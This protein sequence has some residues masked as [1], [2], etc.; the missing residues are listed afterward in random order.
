MIINIKSRQFPKQRDKNNK[1]T[2][3]IPAELEVLFTGFDLSVL[4]WEVQKRIAQRSSK[5][6]QIPSTFDLSIFD[7]IWEYWDNYYILFDPIQFN[8]S[9]RHSSFKC[10]DFPLLGNTHWHW[11]NIPTGR[12]NVIP[13]ERHESRMAVSS[14][15]LCSLPSCV[16][17][18]SSHSRHAFT[19][20][21]G[22]KQ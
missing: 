2:N 7:C 15:V 3:K 5:K 16:V 13:T 8:L 9:C 4:H 22:P 20:L 1:Q 6:K 11:K 12:S 17:L 18:C 14:L 19:R 21:C 10:A